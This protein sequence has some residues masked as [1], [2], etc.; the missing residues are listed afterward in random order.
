[1]KTT[2]V[3]HPLTLPWFCYRP[4][5]GLIAPPPQTLKCIKYA[6]GMWKGCQ[7]FRISFSSL[8]EQPLLLISSS[9]LEGKKREKK[10][11]NLIP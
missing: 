6:F 4:A 11:K 10:L 8:L 2:W 3:L 9:N 7:P 5:G 1:M